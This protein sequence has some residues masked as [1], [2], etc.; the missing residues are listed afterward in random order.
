MLVDLQKSAGNN[1]KNRKMPGSGEVGGHIVQF[2]VPNYNAY[3]K[4]YKQ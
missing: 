2:V 3:G 4:A 1:I